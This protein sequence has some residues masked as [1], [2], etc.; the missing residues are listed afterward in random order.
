MRDYLKL[1][2]FVRPHT[3]LLLLAILCMG[4]SALFEGVQL[5]MIVPLA[6]RVFT[7]KD[8]VIPA[9]LPQF[10]SSFID[11]LNTLS[12]QTILKGMAI[13][14]IVLFFLKGIFLFLQS[15]LMNVVGQATVREVKNRLYKKFQEL[16]LDFYSRKRT[17]ELIA[18]ITNDTGFVSN[19]IS[20]GL[21]DLFFQSMQV[22]LF[23]FLAF[24]IYWKLA[25]I[26]FI[27]FPMILF[28]V[29]KIGKKIKIYTT[30]TQKKVADLNSHLTE[31]IQGAY[32]IKVFGKE[33]YEYNRFKKIN[34]EYFKYI[35]KSIKRMIILSPL[36]E[37]VGAIG[38]T[39]ILIVAGREVIE[40][41]LSFGVFG[42]FLAA[43]MSMIRPFK[44]LSA[45][46]AIN[47]Q[48]L[49]AS[50][51][52][53]DILEEKNQIKESEK[54]VDINGFGDSIVFG[55]VW[56]K[57]NSRAEYVLS[58]INLTIKKNG[59]VALVGY[60][61]AGKSTLVNLIP[62]LYDP[63]KGMVT[64][65]GKN[66]KEVR[67]RSLRNLI[68]VVSQDMI[69]FNDT[70]G[71]NIGYGKSSASQE[72]IIDA[73][74]KAYAHDFIMQLPQKFDTFVGDRGFRLSGGEK[75][76]ITIA[77]AILK[78]SPILILDEATSQL[79]SQSERLIHEALDNL[80]KGRTVFVIAHRLSTAQN[81]TRIIV[82]DKGKIVE[83]GNH[84][85]L[86]KEGTIYKK[87]YELQFNV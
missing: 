44:K 40:G 46:H 10:L 55:H 7:N 37:F 68:S 47:Q 26:S 67:I 18:R 20:T 71:N 16:S 29:I 86:L 59:I 81:A 64:I 61:G 48:A 54:A 2:R 77:R 13:T 53:Y 52:I 19:A 65:D 84:A 11:Y 15:F 72:E 51:R 63:Q 87:L 28:P 38:A 60:S 50:G 74:K 24:F 57:Y 32:V 43:L 35:L 21:T 6:D 31:T 3:G 80:M 58:D 39:V 76:R 85:S 8:I 36:T 22:I 1:L 42:L 30:E 62:R 70:I 41:E 82:M 34:F 5:G 73:A 66:L 33:D 56:F 83:E 25:F 14:I 23:T 4:V 75:Q 79:D 27:L 49:A 12:P 9:K 17:G 78:G 45:V 69:L